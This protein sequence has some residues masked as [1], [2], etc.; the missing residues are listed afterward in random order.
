[1]SK[2]ESTS[3]RPFLARFTRTWGLPLIIG[4]TLAL[5]WMFYVN[6]SDG[7][8][9]AA[10]E[11]KP[12]PIDGDRAYGYLKKLCAFGPRIAGSEANTK[13]RKLAA[14]HFKAMGATLR[15]QTFTARHPLTG[16][17]VEMVNL[18]ASFFPDRA[19]RVVFAAHYDTRPFPDR[20]QDP[21]DRRKPFIG[22][23][24]G[25]SGVAL[26]MEMAH[27]L[28]EGSTPWGVDLV[29]LD[30]EELVYESLDGQKAGEYFLG[31]KEF[32]R[33]YKADRKVSK[34]KYAYVAGFVLDMVGGKDAQIPVEQGSN[35]LAPQLVRE[36]WRVADK[37][38]SKTFQQNLGPEVLDDHLAMN[39]AGI[40]TIDIIDFEFPF[41]HT[42]GDLPEECSGETLK[43]VGRVVTAWLA[44][45]KAAR[46]KKR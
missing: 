27:H 21:A 11:P 24:D 40:H 33:L 9:V 35:R 16:K 26:L 17:K 13:Q 14:D 3:R 36:V 44:Q 45:P 7:S 8:S 34:P 23:N 38:K 10:E 22:A 1:M 6:P 30:G 32:S 15:E 12:A 25:A 39:A 42:A 43:E 28:K 31:S 18:V 20:E 41:W 5:V 2:D 37:L 19:E 29:M 46:S 4:S